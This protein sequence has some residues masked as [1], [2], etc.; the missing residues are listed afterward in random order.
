[1]HVFETEMELYL[2][3]TEVGFLTTD[4]NEGSSHPKAGLNPTRRSV[5]L[6]VINIWFS[7]VKLENS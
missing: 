5:C 4:G 3:K 1:M 2:N 7:F 6:F